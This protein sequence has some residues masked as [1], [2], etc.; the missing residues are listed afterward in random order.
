M[1]VNSSAKIELNTTGTE[2]FIAYMEG[3]KVSVQRYLI[4]LPLATIY[5]DA[6]ATGNNDGSS[7]TDAFTALQLAITASTPGFSKIWVS[8]GTYKPG[9]YKNRFIF[10]K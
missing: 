6:T 2:L 8:Q 1:Q 7:W 5:F 9:G 3:D 4:T 10:N